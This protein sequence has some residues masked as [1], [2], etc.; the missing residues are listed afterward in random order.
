MA[1]SWSNFL[2]KLLTDDAETTWSGSSFHGVTQ[3]VRSGLLIKDYVK[4]R[5]G[6][7]IHLTEQPITASAYL[8][9]S[10]YLSLIWSLFVA[11]RTAHLCR[12]APV[13]AAGRCPSRGC[14][15]GMFLDSI[16]LKCKNVAIL[17]QC[18][19]NIAASIEIRPQKVRRV[20]NRMLFGCTTHPANRQA[21]WP[22]FDVA[23]AEC[24]GM[25][26]LI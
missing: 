7:Q 13:T 20:K 23:A 25:L 5:H 17:W 16:V 14:F 9:A 18:E 8:Y 3:G 22:S 15:V 26:W 6:M 2:L 1:Q 24:A 21:R 19:I 4:W 11:T 10:A 12:T